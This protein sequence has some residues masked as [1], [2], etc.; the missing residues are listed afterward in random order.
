VPA[1]A[2]GR[3]RRGARPAEVSRAPRAQGHLL[4]GRH[5]IDLT[6]AGAASAQ[7]ELV[8]RRRQLVAGHYYSLLACRRCMR[9]GVVK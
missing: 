9:K 7:T 8:R 2:G 6:M 3:Q 5:L 1:D 4:P